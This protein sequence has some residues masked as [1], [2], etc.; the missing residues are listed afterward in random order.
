[1][2]SSRGAGG[3]GH[4]PAGQSC[5]VGQQQGGSGAW[6]VVEV[7]IFTITGKFNVDRPK[8]EIKLRLSGKVICGFA[9]QNLADFMYIFG[10]L[11]NKQLAIFQQDN[12]EHLSL[13]A[14]P[15]HHKKSQKHK[16]TKTKSKTNLHLC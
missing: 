12:L 1:V 7:H 4:T 14:K 11:L 8:G 13:K 10:K 15:I 6:R 9:A 16:I 3:I 5:Q 2:L